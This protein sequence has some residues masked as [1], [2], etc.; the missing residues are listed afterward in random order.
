MTRDDQD[1]PY[2][3]DMTLLLVVFVTLEATYPK[4]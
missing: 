1:K 4:A 2:N 3:F